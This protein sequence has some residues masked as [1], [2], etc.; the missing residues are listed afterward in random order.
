MLDGRRGKHPGRDLH[1]RPQSSVR[2]GKGSY[3]LKRNISV[4]HDERAIAPTVSCGC[5]DVGEGMIGGRY[6]LPVDIVIAKRD[7]DPRRFVPFLGVLSGFYGDAEDHSEEERRYE[8]VEVEEHGC[9]VRPPSTSP[10][11]ISRPSIRR[12]LAPTRKCQNKNDGKVV[13]WP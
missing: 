12:C 6:S 3:P 10:R 13:T 5:P 8:S 11:F 4:R 1:S 2:R 9:C 7:D